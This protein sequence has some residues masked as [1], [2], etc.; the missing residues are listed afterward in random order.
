MISMELIIRSRN[1][2]SLLLHTDSVG[3]V[4]QRAW[5]SEVPLEH[6]TP[7]DG[8]LGAG[9]EDQ[10]RSQRYTSTWA[11]ENKSRAPFTESLSELA[12]TSDLGHTGEGLACLLHLGRALHLT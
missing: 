2:L 11:L 1:F 9:M 4:D 3:T 12:Q 7:L 10:Q 6:K 8:A 5:L